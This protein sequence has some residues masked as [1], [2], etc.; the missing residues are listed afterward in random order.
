[1]LVL[2]SVK[3]SLTSSGG[4]SERLVMFEYSLLM[5][6]T[7]IGVYVAVITM[8]MLTSYSWF[9]RGQVLLRMVFRA[10]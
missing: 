5:E 1:M 9:N 7:L 10:N 2:K 6:V 8:I 3:Y 4:I